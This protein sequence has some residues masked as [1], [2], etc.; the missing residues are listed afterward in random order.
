MGT[1]TSPGTE[2]LSSLR[3]M[4][5]LMVSNY[6]QIHPLGK[7]NMFYCKSEGPTQN[8]HCTS[9]PDCE[10]NIS[11]KL[12]LMQLPWDRDLSFYLHILFFPWTTVFFINGRNVWMNNFHSPTN[13]VIVSKI[14]FSAGA[15]TGK[16]V[17]I[18]QLDG[19]KIKLLSCWPGKI[20]LVC[21]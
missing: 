19:P 8:L 6:T 20:G 2:L 13:V 1:V 17:M 11:V 7:L 14:L 15:A 12:P 4:S 5:V 16:C 10:G 21:P 9:S 18:D 3:T